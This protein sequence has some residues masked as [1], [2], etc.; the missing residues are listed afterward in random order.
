MIKCISPTQISWHF[1]WMQIHVGSSIL[2]LY[3]L[4]FPFCTRSVWCRA[5]NYNLKS[6]Y[7]KM[8]F[9]VCS[10]EQFSSQNIK[11][12]NNFFKTW[13]SIGSLD[14][15]LAKSP[16]D[17][18][19]V[20]CQCLNSLFK[21]PCLKHTYIY[22]RRWNV[23]ECEGAYCLLLLFFVRLVFTCSVDYQFIYGIQHTKTWTWWS[24]GCWRLTC[25]LQN[26]SS[27]AILFPT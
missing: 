6:G 24:P 5:F 8:Y 2:D 12:I 20:L 14:T 16:H 10:N 17:I 22:C 18:N 7:K 25:P 26:T 3:C 15:C 21:F 4:L 23:V 19:C 9:G 11:K 13:L 1:M 27:L